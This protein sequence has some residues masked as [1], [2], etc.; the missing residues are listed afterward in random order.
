MH[1]V[2]LALAERGRT[3]SWLAAESGVHRRTLHAWVKGL[4]PMPERHLG[5]VAAALG[6]PV[7]YVEGGPVKL[8][9]L[10]K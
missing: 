7:E 9:P 3:M 10:P 2:K 6:V 1:P 5:A 8:V 4:R